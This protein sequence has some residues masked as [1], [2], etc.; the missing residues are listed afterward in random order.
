[1]N[2]VELFIPKFWLFFCSSIKRRIQPPRF[3]VALQVLEGK[4]LHIH[5]VGLFW[6][7]SALRTWIRH[8]WYLN[9][10]LCCFRC[11]WKQPHCCSSQI[12]LPQT[13]PCFATSCHSAAETSGHGRIVLHAHTL[14]IWGCFFPPDYKRHAQ[15][16]CSGLT[17]VCNSSTLGGQ[18]GRIIWAQEFKTNLGHIV[19]PHL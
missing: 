7:A 17:P 6:T 14:F 1:M 10:F 13:W 12:H 2:W 5:T 11:S 19:R 9:C 4:F 16:T 8:T 3:A 18:G 15:A